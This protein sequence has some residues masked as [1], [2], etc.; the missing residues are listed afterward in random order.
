MSVKALGLGWTF[1]WHLIYKCYSFMYI[2]MDFLGSYAQA[3]KLLNL[4]CLFR[5]RF[6]AALNAIYSVRNVARAALHLYTVRT[7]RSSL[8]TSS[9][10][11]LCNPPL[12]MHKEL[13]T[14]T[15]WV[16]MS[17]AGHLH[18]VIRAG[19]KTPDCPANRNS[20]TVKLANRKEEMWQVLLTE[21]FECE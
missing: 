16:C 6:E 9:C 4:S 18:D 11:S 19:K 7:G 14:V 5:M 8:R 12:W 15:F 10:N 3:P 17:S 2:L 20:P 13:K 1:I 21:H